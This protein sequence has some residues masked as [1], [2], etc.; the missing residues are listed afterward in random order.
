[1]AM[2]ITCVFGDGV[3]TTA[4]SAN[5]ALSELLSRKWDQAL[6]QT[7]ELSY[8][9]GQWTLRDVEMGTQVQLAG[10]APNVNSI[11]LM[12]PAAVQ[13]QTLGVNSISIVEQ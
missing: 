5:G 7:L 6:S 3:Y 11:Q 2:G 10:G 13:A 4:L 9:Q 8:A 12:L 1:M